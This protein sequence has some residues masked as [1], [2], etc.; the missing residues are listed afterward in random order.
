MYIMLSYEITACMPDLAAMYARH[1][2]SS[3]HAAAVTKEASSISAPSFSHPQ[4][5]RRRAIN[6]TAAPRLFGAR[7][8][9]KRQSDR[10]LF[11]DDVRLHRPEHPE[12]SVLILGRNMELI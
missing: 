4:K 7:T 2:R 6:A 11:P 3:N 5:A 9:E 1:I 8:P 10:R 12:Q